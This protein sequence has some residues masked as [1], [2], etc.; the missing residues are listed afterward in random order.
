[1][2]EVQL[3]GFRDGVAGARKDFDKHRELDVNDRKEYRNPH[4][5]PDQKDA[6][7]DG[8]RL[9]YERA[10]SHFISG[11]EQPVAML[12]TKIPEPAR[13][14]PPANVA[15]SG[16]DRIRE[17]SSE[18]QRRG[19]QDGMICARKDLENHR[20]TDANDESRDLKLSPDL[21]LQYMA[22][23]SQGY[24]HFMSLLAGGPLDR[25]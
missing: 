15:T 3:L 19:F 10:A 18:I 11:P 22:A 7:C 4:L 1:L 13:S 12:E 8:F 20:R 5:P 25:H 24:D 6:Y 2:P 21:R 14:T 17:Q 23:F 16:S 9:G